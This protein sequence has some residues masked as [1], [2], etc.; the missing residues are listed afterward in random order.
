MRALE[1]QHISDSYTSRH[2][3]GAS[4]NACRCICN[5]ISIQ[6][7]GNLQAEIVFMTLKPFFEFKIKSKM[8]GK[9]TNQ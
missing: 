8:T 9:K 2:D 5:K 6:I 4:S 1:F 3:T 7:G